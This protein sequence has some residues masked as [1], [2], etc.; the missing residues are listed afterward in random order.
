PAV[1]IHGWRPGPEL[2]LT[3]TS[4]VLRAASGSFPCGPRVIGPMLKAV[5]VVV[6]GASGN[7]GTALLRW[8]V[9]HPAVGPVAVIA[10]HLPSR[11]AS[12][13]HA[14]TSWHAVDLGDPDAVD[15]LT[16]VFAGAQAV[17]HLAWRITADHDREQQ[18]RT[19]RQGSAAVLAA[20][21]R[22]G[23]G[24]LTFL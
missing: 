10:R 16:E 20:V 6:T 1:S 23:V 17:V 5:R 13:E 11:P 7:I 19:N 24:H 15:R 12:Q 21:R 4:C 2:S 3:A 8:L 14:R 22:A 18:K 9:D